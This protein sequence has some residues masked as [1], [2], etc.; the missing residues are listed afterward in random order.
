M[1]VE[2][3]AYF[4]P[5]PK[6]AATILCADCGAPVDGTIAGAFCY[7]CLKLKTDVTQGVPRD[8]TLHMCRDCDRWLSPPTS[9][10]V[11]PPESREL[12]ALCLRKLRGLNKLRIIDA[13]FIWTEPHSR[14][15]K[16]KITVQ[17]E[18]NEGAIMQQSFEVEYTQ[19]YQQCPDCMK[20]FTHNTWRATVQ[21]RQK[22]PHK[23]TFLYLEQLILRHG[24]HQNT[25]NIKEQHDGIDFFFAQ[26]NHAEAFVDF[27]K[28]VVPVHV[29]KSQE[30]ISM[31]IHTSTK[32]YKFSY[33]AELL[34]ICKDDLVVLPLALAKKSGNISPLTICHRIGTSLSLLDPTTLQ[35][36]DISTDVFFRTPFRSL[37][38]AHDLTEFI[39]LDVEPLGT[40]KGRYFLAEA[41]VA[42]ASDMGANETTYY[43]RTHLGG[44][45]HAGDS[46]MGYHLSGA[47]Y[48][49]ELFDKLEDSKHA[50]TIPDVILVKKFYQ[51]SKKSKNNRTWRLKRINKEA[52][53]MLPR[54]Q[55]KERM[56]RDFEM[57]LRDVEEDPELRAGLALYKA[58][59][60]E[61][62]ALED[63][64][65]TAESEFGDEDAGLTIP[66]EQLLDDFED[67]SMNE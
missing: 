34:P 54:K 45:L 5:A 9:W 47:N 22:V 17:Q 48:N 49:N 33:S 63:A 36:A 11:A 28:A 2:A 1:E 26:R 62:Q 32:S 51:R 25:I 57:F 21:V 64:M 53:E 50:S 3:P 38:D 14:R 56:E 59:Q 58:Q 55:D 67:M 66:M 23:R 4:T 20:S 65:D 15:I 12:L 24:A 31:D 35:T 29:K 61:Q 46:V 8:A 60:K 18:I 16:V 40:Q 6:S 27:L 37:A 13:S 30:L 52:S 41:T 43:T 42:K 10:V 19:N 44:V 7:D 39:V